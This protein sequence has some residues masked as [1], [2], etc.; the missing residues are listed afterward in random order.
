MDGG[1]YG[2]I[3]FMPYLIGLL[4]V[5][6]LFALVGFWRVGASYATQRSAQIGSVAADGEAAGNAALSA[7]WRGWT[8]RD[9]A[10]GGVTVDAQDRSVGANINAMVN[11]DSALFGGWSLPIS[12]GGQMSVRSERFYPGQPVCDEDGAN[13][14]E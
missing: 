5:G 1:S 3:I 2:D 9:L 12:A 7:I 10:S 8:G 4:L 6:L 11:Y 14:G 13:C